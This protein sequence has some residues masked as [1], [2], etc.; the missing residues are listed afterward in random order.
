ML[1]IT[2][3]ESRR[4]ALEVHDGARRGDHGASVCLAQIWSHDRSLAGTSP[5]ATRRCFHKAAQ[6][7]GMH[8]A[9]CGIHRVDEMQMARL[10]GAYGTGRTCHTMPW[11]RKRARLWAHF[12]TAATDSAPPEMPAVPPGKLTGLDEDD[13]PRRPARAKTITAIGAH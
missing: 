8:A 1:S 6:I 3:F 13:S 2:W 7:L 12:M 10:L 5:E 11:A 4:W 9:R